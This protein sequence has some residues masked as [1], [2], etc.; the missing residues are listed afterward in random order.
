MARKQ[1]QL[2]I[3]G[4][5]YRLTQLG[6]AQGAELWLDLL[7]VVAGPFEALGRSMSSASS[8]DEEK[9]TAA[10]IATVTAAIRSLDHATVNKLYAAFGPA[11]TIRVPGAPGQ[12]DRWPTLDGAVFDDHFA[13]NYLELTEWLVRSVLFNFL[14]FFDAGSLGSVG[15]V[16]REAVSRAAS[17]MT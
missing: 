11:T 2:T 17:S 1:T 14:P 4:T 9:A 10:G 16:L 8:D 12:G 6:A 13:G 15:A 5:D 3:N 7:R